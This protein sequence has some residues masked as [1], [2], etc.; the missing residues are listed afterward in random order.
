MRSSRWPSWESN[1]PGRPFR[2]IGYVAGEHR[3]EAFFRSG[4]GLGVR[5]TDLHTALLS[6]VRAAGV[7][8]LSRAVGSVRQD[9]N[10]VTRSGSDRPVPGGS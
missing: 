3:A 7:P 2:G 1:P 6:A 4:S 8:V 10:S 9:E 5:R